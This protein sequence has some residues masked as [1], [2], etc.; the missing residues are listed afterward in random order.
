MARVAT[1]VGLG[2][3]QP[4]DTVSQAPSRPFQM[5]TDALRKYP[6]YTILYFTT[7]Y[8]HL[9]LCPRPH[10]NASPNKTF[11]SRFDRVAGSALQGMSGQVVGSLHPDNV[12]R[13]PTAG[14]AIRLLLLA[15]SHKP[16]V[17]SALI[18]RHETAGSAPMKLFWVMYVIWRE[19][20]AERRG[21]GQILEDALEDAVRE[22][23]S[24]R[25]VLLG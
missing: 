19:G 13:L 17:S 14:S 18:E 8:L 22:S 3:T 23:A 2:D 24:V 5:I 16:T 21:I 20:V 6:P 15:R 7:I 25:T 12:D 4:R 11:P 10:N 1:S 9:T